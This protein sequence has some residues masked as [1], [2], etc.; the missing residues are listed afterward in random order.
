MPTCYWITGLPGS[1]KTRLAEAIRDNVYVDHVL[2]DGDTYRRQSFPNAGFSSE[3]RSL[4]CAGAAAR[5]RSILAHGK[6]VICAFVS[7]ERHIRDT[8]R[9]IIEPVADFREIYVSTPLSVCEYRDPKG[10][11]AKAR[12]GKIADMTGVQQPYEAPENP[13]FVAD[14]GPTA[15]SVNTLL[16]SQHGHGL[17]GSMLQCKACDSGAGAWQALHAALFSAS[18]DTARLIAIRNIQAWVLEH[19]LAWNLAGRNPAEVAREVIAKAA[20]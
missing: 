14:M 16:G 11:Y 10:L 4:V 6:S 18:T 19:P 8:V 15:E 13:F 5:A 3:D 20:I 12:A 17:F 7:P 2:F 9:S 1:G